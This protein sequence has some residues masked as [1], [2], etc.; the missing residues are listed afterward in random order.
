[1]LTIQ[2]QS[3]TGVT[4]TAPATAAPA[5]LTSKSKPVPA[6]VGTG[7]PGALCRKAPGQ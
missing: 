6:A 5:L 4:S 1:M 2:F 3:S 7:D